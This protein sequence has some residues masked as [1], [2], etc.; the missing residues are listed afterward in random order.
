MGAGIPFSSPDGRWPISRL[1]PPSPSGPHDVEQHGTD[2]QRR[3]RPPVLP[4][5]EPQEHAL[6]E[7]SDAPGHD[8]DEVTDADDVPTIIDPASGHP[9]DATPAIDQGPPFHHEGLFHAM[10]ACLTACQ[11]G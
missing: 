9:G 7:D 6:I 11:A 4:F 8:G 10:V 2:R 5:K 3:A 1:A